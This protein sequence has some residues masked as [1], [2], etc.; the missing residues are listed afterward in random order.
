MRINFKNHASP[1]GTGTTYRVTL[2]DDRQLSLPAG[3]P[4][5]A[6]IIVAA[7]LDQTCTVY[8]EWAPD[9]DAADAAL[10]IMNGNGTGDSASTRFVQKYRRLPGRNRISIVATG[11][12]PTATKVAVEEDTFDGPQV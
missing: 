3:L 10:V 6:W 12:A 8:H 1:A 2:Y 11:S 5:T 4:S 9:R 7:N